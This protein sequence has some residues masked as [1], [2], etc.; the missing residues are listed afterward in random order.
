MRHKVAHNRGAESKHRPATE[1]R[2]R[3][4]HETQNKL[5]RL[6]SDG[7]IV[8]GFHTDVTFENFY[9]WRGNPN[10]CL[11]TDKNHSMAVDNGKKIDWQ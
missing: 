9:T 5:K 7:M 6:T 3:W 2:E 1:N 11:L 8:H 10:G 4:E